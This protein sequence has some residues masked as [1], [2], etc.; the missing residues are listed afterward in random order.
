MDPDEGIETVFLVIPMCPSEEKVVTSLK[1]LVDETGKFD[2]QALKKFAREHDQKTF[3]SVMP[4]WIMVGSGLHRGWNLP[5]EEGGG[6]VAG[7]VMFQPE[8][9]K[10]EPT[11][12]KILEHSVFPLV[13]WKSGFNEY[14]KKNIVTI[15][16]G[17]SVKCDIVLAEPSIS[18]EHAEFRLD[19]GD[20]TLSP[21][22]FVR[23][24]GSSNGVFVNGSR[25]APFWTK[26]VAAGDEIR[27]SRFSVILDL[28]VNLHNKLKYG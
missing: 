19:V 26:N 20:G 13:P 3:L 5:V 8:Q 12:L 18:A 1:D 6:N 15:I 2:F 11:R 16:M 7:T 9:R 21:A 27:F 10:Q 22:C 23:D 25:L 28:P 4:D 17:R 14:R 24:M